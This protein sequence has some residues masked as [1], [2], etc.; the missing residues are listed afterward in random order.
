VWF[1]VAYLR[2]HLKTQHKN[3]TKLPQVSLVFSLK[4]AETVFDL[5]LKVCS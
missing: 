5:R 1:Y 4:M 3:R 2:I